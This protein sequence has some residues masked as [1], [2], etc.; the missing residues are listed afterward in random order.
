MKKSFSDFILA[1]SM[2]ILPA[3]AAPRENVERLF[4]PCRN[5]APSYPGSKKRGWQLTNALLATRSMMAEM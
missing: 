4:F 2:S 3:F 5:R 1:E